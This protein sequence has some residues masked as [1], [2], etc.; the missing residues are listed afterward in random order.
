MIE[1]FSR[2]WALVKASAAVLRSDKELLLF[3]ALSALCSL[4]VLASFA[5]RCS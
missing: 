1:K 5:T 3:P 4:L 2:S